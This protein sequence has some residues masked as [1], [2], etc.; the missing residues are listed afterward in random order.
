MSTQLYLA[1]GIVEGRASTWQDMT[2]LRTVGLT[3]KNMRS[4]A[5]RTSASR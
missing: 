3:R 2:S 4:A 1:R 5:R